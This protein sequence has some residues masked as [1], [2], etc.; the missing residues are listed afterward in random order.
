MNS[1]IG[2]KYYINYLNINLQIISIKYANKKS[3]KKNLN[4]EHLHP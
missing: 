3:I 4:F 1:K 2:P